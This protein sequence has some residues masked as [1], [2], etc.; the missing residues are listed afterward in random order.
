MNA[1][2]VYTP[3][4]FPNLFN[5]M[6]TIASAIHFSRGFTQRHLERPRTRMLF[7]SLA[8]NG[9]FFFFFLLNINT[10]LNIHRNMKY[11]WTAKIEIRLRLAYC[12]MI[13][14][15]RY[16]ISSILNNEYV[17]AKKRISL[18]FSSSLSIRVISFAR[19]FD[20]LRSSLKNHIR[21]YFI[22]DYILQVWIYFSTKF[23]ETSVV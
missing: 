2:I 20:F 21:S 18:I 12:L 3:P 6:L 9:S 17:T 7:S 23:V 4:F 10:L 1:V 15:V 14:K 11:M 5:R 13:K 22:N 16:L 8:N 19:V